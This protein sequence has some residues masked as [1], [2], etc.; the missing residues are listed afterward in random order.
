MAGEWIVG[1]PSHS[2]EYMGHILQK[3]KGE[4]DWKRLMEYFEMS[5]QEFL[6]TLGKVKVN[7]ASNIPGPLN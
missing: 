6:E 2:R 4:E 5:E 1:D 3:E 7:R